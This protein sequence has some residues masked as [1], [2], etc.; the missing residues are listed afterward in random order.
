M[1]GAVARG[2]GLPAFQVE[3]EEVS[4][5]VTS[6]P[7]PR[8]P[9]GVPRLLWFTLFLAAGVAASVL[10]DALFSDVAIAATLAAGVVLIGVLR[11]RRRTSA[12]EK[13]FWLRELALCLARGLA[14]GAIVLFCAMACWFL[15]EVASGGRMPD[16]PLWVSRI[17]LAEFLGLQLFLLLRPGTSRVG[18]IIRRIV[19]AVILAGL[20]VAL[21]LYLV[22]TGPAD[23]TRYPA[24][25]SSPYRLP[26]PA[27]VTRLCMQSNRGIVSHRGDEEYAYDFAMP[28]GSV[29]C[30]ARAGV[31]VEVVDV[32]DGNGTQWPNNDIIV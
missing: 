1:N 21:V 32:W 12:T 2:A 19:V 10:A 5:S 14:L 9:F 26:W 22:L 6:T 28:A 4:E 20:A 8:T 3:P 24:A 29:F 27:G 23:P 15:G 17:V 25:A 13:P 7:G 16:V 18:E 30:A 31:V 11:L